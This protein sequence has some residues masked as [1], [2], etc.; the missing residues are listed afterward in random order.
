MSPILA[1]NSLPPTPHNLNPL[2]LSRRCII[3]KDAEIT[4]VKAEIWN[5]NDC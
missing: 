2:P 4:V 3:L 5:K 1:T